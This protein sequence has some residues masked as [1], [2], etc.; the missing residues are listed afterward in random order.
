VAE[1]RKQH[2]INEQTWYRWKKEFGQMGVPD[3]RR[4]RV[5]EGEQPARADRGERDLEVDARKEVL[6]GSLYMRANV[7]RPY[8]NCSS[9]GFRNA[10]RAHSPL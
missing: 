7:V 6:R 2:G 8:A 4:L 1:V 9:V 10:G 3:V 5:G